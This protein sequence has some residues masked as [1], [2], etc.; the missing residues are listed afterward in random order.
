MSSYTHR[1]CPV[2]AQ[3]AGQSLSAVCYSHR[4]IPEA[5]LRSFSLGWCLL[6]VLSALEQ[7]IPRII[8]A[9]D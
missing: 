6:Y 5:T 1:L 4:P 9:K 8:V 3:V 2:A 7:L